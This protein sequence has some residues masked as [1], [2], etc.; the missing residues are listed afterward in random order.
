[1]P[2]RLVAILRFPMLMIAT[3][4]EDGNAANSLR[5]DPAFKLSLGHM[6]NGAALCSQPTISRLENQPRPTCAPDAAHRCLLAHVI[7]TP[8]DAGPVCGS[9]LNPGASLSSTRCGCGC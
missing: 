7:A 2:D 8:T 3:G 4:Y 1:V 6:P 5:H 9:A